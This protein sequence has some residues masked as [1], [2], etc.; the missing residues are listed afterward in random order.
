MKCAHDIPILNG[1]PKSLFTGFYQEKKFDV[2]MDI[3]STI[4]KNK[5]QKCL[6]HLHVAGSDNT[7]NKT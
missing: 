5:F 3:V 2:F 7:P 4:S 1:C 6:Q